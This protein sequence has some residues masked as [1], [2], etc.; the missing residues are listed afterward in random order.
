MRRHAIPCAAAEPSEDARSEGRADAQTGRAEPEAEPGA[1]PEQRIEQPRL[2]KRCAPIEA[3]DIPLRPPIMMP[4]S[5]K[6]LDLG[7][8][9]EQSVVAKALL[10]ERQGQA[11]ARDARISRRQE[12]DKL[13]ARPHRARQ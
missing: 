11:R 10:Q 1:A 5:A 4:G 7:A 9:A 2:F 8:R 12:P 13:G 3:S 6:K